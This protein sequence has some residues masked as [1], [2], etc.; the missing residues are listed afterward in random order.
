M[1]RAHSR[2]A[3]RRS[4]P[5][6]RLLH[7]ALWHERHPPSNLNSLPQSTPFALRDSPACLRLSFPLSSFFLPPTPLVCNAT[8]SNVLRE[9]ETCRICFTLCIFLF[10]LYHSTFLPC[11]L[12]CYCGYCAKVQREQARTGDKKKSRLSGLQLY[13]LFFDLLQ[14]KTSM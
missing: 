4:L 12:F 7:P 10:F 6:R 3:L 11:Y 9:P 14:E 1:Q 13:G 2:P 8:H 5:L